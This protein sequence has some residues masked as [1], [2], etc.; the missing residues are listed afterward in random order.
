MSG[1]D[2]KNKAIVLG[3]TLDTF[4]KIG[5]TSPAL[6]NVLTGYGMKFKTWTK[7]PAFRRRW[8]TNNWHDIGPHVGFAYRAFDG[9]KSFVIRGGYALNYFLIPIYGWND[10]MRMNTPVRGLLPKLR[11]HAM[12]RSLRTRIG[13]WGLV[14]APTIVAGKNSANAVTLRPSRWASPPARSPSKTPISIRTSPL[15]ACTTGT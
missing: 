3:N 8:S 2:K 9:R 12:R 13:N 10:R 1:F 5:A 15:P 11:A 14:N 6:I 7:R 4:Y